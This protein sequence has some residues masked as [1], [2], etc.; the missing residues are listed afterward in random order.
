MR[1]DDGIFQLSTAF[2]PSGFFDQL[3]G[4]GDGAAVSEVP[5]QARVAAVSFAEDISTLVIGTAFV[6]RL[7][8]ARDYNSSEFPT[9]IDPVSSGIHATDT[10]SQPSDDFLGNGQSGYLIE[11]T[12]SSAGLVGI[13]EVVGGQAGYIFPTS[14]D[15]SQYSIVGTGDYLGDGKSDLLVENIGG[16][17]GLIGIGEISNGQVAFTFPTALTP[18]G[19]WNVVGSGDFLGD[20]ND[21]F[22]IENTGANAG[23]VGIGELTGG[24]VAFTFPTALA[25]SQWNIVGVGDFLG[26]GKSDILIEN[27]GSNAGLVGI[28]EV[29]GGQVSFSFPTAVAA[30][31]WKFVG[32]GDF[33][34]DGKDQFLI[35]NIGTSA[36]LLGIGEANNGQVAFTFPTTLAS[37]WTIVGTGD[38]LAEGHDQIL[39]E[40]TSGA[41]DIGDYTAGQVH[42]TQVS[43]LPPDWTFH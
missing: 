40:S 43:S 25:T 22:L 42:L 15:P 4:E 26:D 14:L 27:I 35:E 29:T 37:Q 8:L 7:A 12:G 41:I 31:Q 6:D 3:I 39:L 19:Q 36:G 5:G 13:G 23:L 34:G 20:G 30:G 28:G 24:Q 38:Y 17:A 1:F 33:F 18:S 16:A 2:G 9:T 11:N 21:Q 32:T 10:S